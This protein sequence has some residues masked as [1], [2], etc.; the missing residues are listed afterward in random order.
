MKL[1]SLNINIVSKPTADL[2]K[3]TEYLQAEGFSWT[4]DVD[5]TPGEKLVE[6]AGRICYMS[7]SK[8]M[9]KIRYPN[10]KYIKNIID[11]GHESVLEHA[12]WSFILSGVSRAFSHQLVRHRVGFAFSQLSQQYTMNL[13]QA[14][15]FHMELK[16]TVASINIGRMQSVKQ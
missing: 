12:S 2:T 3:V 6:V 16:R 14:L 5:A 9:S 11:K 15:Y 7:F 13:T 8:D 4:E 1:A 10:S